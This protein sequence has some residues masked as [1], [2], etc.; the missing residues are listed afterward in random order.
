MASRCFYS[1]MYKAGV[2]EVGVS[3]SWTRP[4]RRRKLPT[5]FTKLPFRGIR[6]IGTAGFFLETTAHEWEQ[7]IW[8]NHFSPCD[9]GDFVS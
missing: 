4:V 9:L 8:S 5:Q 6:V 2:K 7:K 3:N 1:L